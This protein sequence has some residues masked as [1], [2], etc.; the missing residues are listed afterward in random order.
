MQFRANSNPS[1]SFF[2]PVLKYMFFSTENTHFSS[3]FMLFLLLFAKR[4]E[5]Q[6]F[7]GMMEKQQAGNPAGAAQKVSCPAD[8]GSTSMPP[9]HQS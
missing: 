7:Y 4:L 2:H 9:D 5:S 8:L 3:L 1:K 6:L